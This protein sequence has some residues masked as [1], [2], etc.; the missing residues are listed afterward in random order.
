M[1]NKLTSHLQS[2][3][4]VVGV[5]VGG[6]QIRAAVLRG[7]TLLSRVELP[8]GQD[9]TPDRLI[10]RLSHAIDQALKAAKIDLGDILGIG[11]AVAGEL[12]SQTGVIFSAP[13]LPAWSQVPLRSLLEEQF[14]VPIYVENDASLA[15]LAEYELGAGRG[16]KDVVYLTISTG[17]GGGVISDGQLMEGASGT[18]GEL[19]HMT[20]DWHGGRC[21]CGNIGCLE[22]LASGTAIARLANEAVSSGH[23]AELLAFA[24]RLEEDHA[25]EAKSSTL[26]VQSIPLTT[27][28]DPHRAAPAVPIDARI[29]ALAAE[30]GVSQ[31]C[32]IIAQAA[33]ALG[34]GLVNIIHIFNPQRIILGGGVAKI[35]SP[36]IE[37]AKAIVQER[38]IKAFRDSVQIVQAQLGED[39]GL[40]GA[41]IRVYQKQG[42]HMAQNISV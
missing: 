12:D 30:A 24:Q 9:P 28:P 23:G 36:L 41:A 38:A 16:Y 13:N 6:S 10:P 19:G 32:S 17:I 18:G 26:S 4:L 34:V 15:A 35:G 27:W 14:A 29:V 22:Y 2:L 39:A 40:I 20:V 21:N 31:A 1:N 25:A 5:D 8:T 3:P 7:A 42:Q 37:P 11:V 33:E